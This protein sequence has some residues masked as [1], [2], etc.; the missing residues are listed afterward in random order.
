MPESQAEGFLP[1]LRGKIRE[2]IYGQSRDNKNI[3]S[4]WV[5]DKLSSREQAKQEEALVRLETIAQRVDQIWGNQSIRNGKLKR[6]DYEWGQ[7]GH[8]GNYQRADF[9]YKG[10]KQGVGFA[11]WSG[12]INND[13]FWGELNQVS[14]YISAGKLNG[15]HYSEG[16]YFQID[17]AKPLTGYNKIRRMSEVRLGGDQLLPNNLLGKG[18]QDVVVS[19]DGL[20]VHH[21]QFDNALEFKDRTHATVFY[22]S[23]TVEH[24]DKVYKKNIG[25]SPDGPICRV[26]LLMSSS[27]PWW[28][29]G[30]QTIEGKMDWLEMKMGGDGRWQ[31]SEMSDNWGRKMVVNGETLSNGDV[32]VSLKVGNETKE[33]ILP[34]IDLEAVLKASEGLVDAIEKNLLSS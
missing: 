10:E 4:R 16:A 15:K 26:R 9:E 22:T 12:V 34:K 25:I 2:S 31:E 20:E 27:Q 33:M 8:R 23:G 1:L 21:N 19:D 18:I 17:T 11:S 7:R 30:A 6:D 28:P 13:R 29:K 5:I 24:D 14:G 32:R 3:A